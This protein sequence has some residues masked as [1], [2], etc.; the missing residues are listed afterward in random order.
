MWA[1]LRDPTRPGHLVTGLIIWSLWFVAQYSVLSLTCG[2]STGSGQSA[3]FIWLRPALLLLALGVALVLLWLA[4]RCWKAARLVSG[5]DHHQGRLITKVCAGVDILL[6]GAT[7]I[8][9]SPV[10]FLPPCL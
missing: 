9:A 1:A 10:V 2:A 4:L 7:L 3:A 8:V 6:A 5:D